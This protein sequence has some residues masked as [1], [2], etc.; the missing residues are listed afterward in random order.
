MSP[1]HKP[2]RQTLL[3][4]VAVIGV[5]LVGAVALYFTTKGLLLLWADI[6]GQSYQAFTR[7]K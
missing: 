6:S 1:Q 3:A 5:A 7:L 2:L 4:G